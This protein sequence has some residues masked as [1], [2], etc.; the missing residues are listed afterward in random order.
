MGNQIR[1]ITNKYIYIYIQIMNDF[2]NNQK[3]DDDILFIYR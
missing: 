1:R 3:N 2:Y